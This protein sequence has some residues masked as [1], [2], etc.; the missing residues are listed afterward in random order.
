M[1]QALLDE[2]VPIRDL[3]RIFEALSTRARSSTEPEGLVEAVR[4][5]LGPA[6]SAPY[7]ADGRLPIITFDP[8]FEQA[9]LEALRTGDSGSFLAVD[10][11]QAEVLATG[12]ARVAEQAEMRG[13]QPVLVC[14]P[15]LRPA[16][17]K[18]VR[19][20]APHLPVLSYAEI[21][22][23]LSLEPMGVVTGVQAAAA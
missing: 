2:H 4:S 12:A 9:L 20:A 8:L 14:S 22:T 19:A 23:A 15:Q 11:H 21:G 18:L 7:A 3:V 5:T 1:L 16:V 10:A 17:R 6:V 13:D